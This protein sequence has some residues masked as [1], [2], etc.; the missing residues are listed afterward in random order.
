[1]S[2]SEG[3][4]LSGFKT[5]TSIARFLP[6]TMAR[7]RNPPVWTV[8]IVYKDALR[9]AD[10]GQAIPGHRGQAVNPPPEARALRAA[11]PLHVALAAAVIAFT[12]QMLW[13]RQ[14][15][16][17]VP[18]WDEWND[19]YGFLE[20]WRA[21]DVTWQAFFAQ[22]MEHRIPVARVFFILVDVIFGEGHPLGILTLHAVLMA[23]IVAIW[24]YTL[25]RLGEPLWL[26]AATLV[27]LM[28]PSQ[29]QNWLWAFQVEFF[30][31][32]GPVL[33][34][35]CWIALAP[36]ITWAGV[37]GCA[38]ACAI[39]SVLAWPRGSRRGPPSA[40][41][42]FFRVCLDRGWA[43]RA[44]LGARREI[45]QI[46][47]FLAPGV[48][49][50]VT[51]FQHYVQLT[52][53]EAWGRS[54]GQMAHW[55][56]EALVFPLVNARLSADVRWLPAALALVFL[57]IAAAMV[58]YARR[59][60]RARLLL[61]AGLLLMV[62]GHAGIIAYGRSGW[63]GVA[64]RY[65]TVFLWTGA[66]S[67]MAMASLMRASRERWRWAAIPI[68]LAAALLLGAHLWRYTTYLEVIRESQ[69]GRLS[70]VR[71]V[72][73]YLSDDSP[74]RQLPGD[75]P[76]PEAPIKPFLQRQSVPRHAPVQSS[77]A[78]SRHRVR[79]RLV[80]RR[81][82][83]GRRRARTVHLGIVD[84]IRCAHRDPDLVA[85]R[86]ASRADPC[87]ERLPDTA[88]QLA[89]GRIGARPGRA[90]GLLRPR[91][92]RRLDRVAR[93]SRP[94]AARQSPRRRGRRTPGGWRM[95]RD[96]FSRGQA[97]R[98]SSAGGR[99]AAH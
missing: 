96:P 34:A 49:M 89:G 53:P 66:I 37:A 25:R 62:A 61:T 15:Y 45:A 16:V 70:W 48:L 85:V 99:P 36:R 39:S 24:I 10:P 54:L 17:S 87:G 21:G 4:E 84:R 93:R 19:L 23:G 30:T 77:A 73:S 97:R 12:V 75:L 67:L 81:R 31:L 95:D 22:H 59:G 60:D 18:Y 2:L 68:G 69:R 55:A 74:G 7:E 38:L 43:W 6:Y 1:M 86:R 91:S 88:R 98:R 76:F 20:T 29:Y 94:V 46:L 41:S 52:P 33:A 26:V 28:S 8:G 57:P 9:L 51:Y 56:A 32:V 50:T 72:T 65:G 35:V 40:C 14:F 71:N 13:V 92:R 42:C 3:L 82:H 78:R 44:M 27:V 47:A 63:V 11:N 80:A 5:E 83:A 90:R 58:M 64:P 79:R